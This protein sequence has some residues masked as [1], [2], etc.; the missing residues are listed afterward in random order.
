MTTISTT[1]HQMA[2]SYFR[3]PPR[4]CTWWLALARQVR[5]SPV[6]KC[7]L[8]LKQLNV[9]SPGHVSHHL[10]PV[11]IRVL[12]TASANFLVVPIRQSVECQGLDM[13]VVFSAKEARGYFDI[14][15]TNQRRGQTLRVMGWSE[16]R[17]FRELGKRKTPFIP[18]ESRYYH[19]HHLE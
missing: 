13:V 14:D 15:L 9:S 7:V 12:T 19:S 11:F 6:H 4:V 10:H 5:V 3:T 1:T 16:D 17:Q 8:E 18:N 2:L